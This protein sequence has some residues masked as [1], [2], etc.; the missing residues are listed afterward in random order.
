MPLMGS[1]YIGV[2]GL[3][4]GQNVLNSTAHNLTNIDTK[5]YTRQQPLLGSRSYITV[6]KNPRAVSNQQYGLGV[7]FSAVRQ[8]RD[9]FLYKTYS[10]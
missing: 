6:S 7:N 5:G 9:Y 4:T 3:Q 10:K 2:S 8:V 1:L